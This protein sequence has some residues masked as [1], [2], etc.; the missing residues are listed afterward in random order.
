MEPLS[1]KA[2]DQIFNHPILKK[3]VLK[4]RALYRDKSCGIG[5]VRAKCR[6]VALGHLDPDLE[7]LQRTSA[8]PGRIAEHIVFA[9]IVAGYN[10]ELL[11]SSLSWTTWIAD[12]ATAFLQGSQEQRALPLYL[13]PPRDGLI[14]LTSTWSSR[15]YRIRGNVYGLA[16][17]PYTWATEV[18]RRLR[19]IDYQQHSFDQQLYYKVVNDQVVSIILVYVDDFVGISRADYPISEVHDLFKWGAMSKLE[20][21]K[22]ATFKGKE[23]TLCRNSHGRFTMKITMEKFIDGLDESLLPRGRLLKGDKLTEEEQKELR[24]ISGSLQ[25]LAT[26]SR[27][28]IAPV[29]SLTAHGDAAT[30]HD[31]KNL[32]ATV[33]YLKQSSKAGILMQDVPVNDDTVILAYSDSSWANASKSGS[34][35]G[36]VIGLTTPLAKHQPAKFSL[37]DW[38]SARAVRVCRSTLAAEASAADEASDRSAYVNMHLGELVHLEPAHRVGVRLA[39]LQATDAKSLF[40]A[41]ISPNTVTNDK[42]TMVSIRTI[43]ETVTKETIR[44]VPT[45]FQFSDGLTKIDEKLRVSFS[46]WLQNPVAILVEHPE[47]ALL[48]Q[49]LFDQA[50]ALHESFS[51]GSTVKHQKNNTSVNF[52]LHHSMFHDH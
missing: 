40:D 20:L 47:N 23:L 50:V 7:T 18:T 38:K 15:L 16:N 28:E 30:I 46:K 51:R 12:A 25:W 19:S 26:Q 21:D 22:P 27:P 17:A 45:R 44:W 10:G 14:A 24:S 29:V 4:N 41:V 33:G 36:V 43:Q 11:S 31:L 48:E 6:V 37:I 42:R 5:E 32:Y 39:F 2:A 49:Q 35:I 8:T 52:S 34:Q 13:L 3:R 9:M 1:D